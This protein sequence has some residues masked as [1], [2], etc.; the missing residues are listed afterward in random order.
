VTAVTIEELAVLGVRRLVAL[1]LAG[2]ID[3]AVASNSVVLVEGAI[4]ADG[5]SMHYC[6]EAV[7]PPSA[8]L[9]AA[10][11]EA[12]RNHGVGF[13][14]G[15]V[16]STDAVY[17]ETPSLIATH[18]SKGAIVV[19]METAAVLTVSAA[20]GIE[21]AAVLVVADEIGD[22]WR[23]PRDMRAVQSHLR[24]LVPIVVACLQT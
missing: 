22:E 24:R 21:A 12:L 15:I 7:M 18:R 20:L 8:R 16:W 6:S 5:T 13:S 17:R 1:D 2:S 9:V 14:R 11:K 23:P 10:L 4:C 19:D 3:P